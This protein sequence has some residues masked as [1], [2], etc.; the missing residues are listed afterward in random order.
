MKISDTGLRHHKSSCHNSSFWSN[1]RSCHTDR[2]EGYHFFSPCEAGFCLASCIIQGSL[3][4]RLIPA[5]LFADHH[6]IA[7]AP[8]F[9]RISPPI[10]E[11]LPAS[12]RRKTGYA[13][14]RWLTLESHGFNAVEPWE[15]VKTSRR[16]A[17]RKLTISLEM[18][19]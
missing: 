13:C 18:R 2:I 10:P 1:F 17:G 5:F 8:H 12:R 7:S 11:T 4:H 6:S 9:A 15:Y 19:S 3:C 16:T 14:G